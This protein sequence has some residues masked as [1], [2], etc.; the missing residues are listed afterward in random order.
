MALAE[1]T[2]PLRQLARTA[3]AAAGRV[4]PW[5]IGHELANE[6]TTNGRS[7]T[8]DEVALVQALERTLD[9][10]SDGDDRQFR[11]WWLDEET[12]LDEVHDRWPVV[13]AAVAAIAEHSTV[14]AHLS[15]LLWVARHGAP[16]LHARR[17][18]DAYLESAAVV[19]E[20][21]DRSRSLIRAHEL[22]RAI[23][24]SE[25]LRA[26]EAHIC[27]AVGAAVADDDVGVALA[28]LDHLLG[29]R[30][31]R[32]A[33]S[34]AAQLL[35]R[36]WRVAS[37]TDHVER[38]GKLLIARTNDDSERQAVA[39]RVV[40]TFR[41]RAA[42]EEGFGRLIA[43]R[44]ALRVAEELGHPLHDEILHEIETLDSTSAFTAIRT[45]QVLSR[46]QVAAFCAG[47]VGDDSLQHA[48]TRFAYQLPITPE[49]VQR[50]RDNTPVSIRHVITSFRIGEAN[51]VVTSTETTSTNDDPT[52]VAVE[53][54]VLHQVGVQ[55]QISAF[56]FLVPALHQTLA[57]YEPW[58]VDDMRSVLGSG[59]AD[60]VV[61]D[62]LARS[63]EHF[64]HRRYDEAV[65]VALPR[66]ERLIRHIARSCGVATTRRPTK[67]VGGIRGL[68][69][70]LD[71]LRGGS[72]EPILPEPLLTSAELTLAEP[73]A[74]NLRN[75]FLHGI[76]NQARAGEAAMILQIGFALALTIQLG[77]VTSEPAT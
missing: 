44:D 56:L 73:D 53:R 45:E 34:A 24:D 5:Q 59:I 3:D 42:Q 58:T 66:V 64:H 41:A 65:H 68:G 23:N 4:R 16:H 63:L 17:A 8:P 70:I 12:S 47:I 32:D 46:Q 30:P 1:S 11:A 49:S 7:M 75:E 27:A 25:R 29:G 2:D 54:D 15:D 57:S 67:R 74:L 62:A 60:A 18:I 22:A 69:E 10:S 71:D 38:A 21:H 61:A 36:A 37:R 20:P 26:V 52:A 39:D 9:W 13:W 14:V 31:S 77:P 6:L 76:S 19:V 28:L 48:L 33:A 43:L 55:A 72:G 40:S 35:S 51:S 50:M